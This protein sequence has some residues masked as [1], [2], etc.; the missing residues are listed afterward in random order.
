MRVTTDSLAVSLLAE[1]LLHRHRRQ[2]QPTPLQ[3]HPAHGPPTH[4]PTLTNRSAAM[5]SHGP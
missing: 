2:P 4:P 3:P 5:H 1:L